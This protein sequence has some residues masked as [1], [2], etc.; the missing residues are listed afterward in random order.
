VV[1]GVNLLG[2]ARH[3][4][5]ALPAQ[6]LDGGEGQHDQGSVRHRAIHHDTPTDLVARES[7]LALGTTG[8]A[9]L[10]ELEIDLRSNFLVGHLRNDIPPERGQGLDVTD[11]HTRSR[12]S[13]QGVCHPR[14][15]RKSVMPRRRRAGFMT[16]SLTSSPEGA[17]S[18]GGWRVS[19]QSVQGASRSESSAKTAHLPPPDPSDFLT[20]CIWSLPWRPRRFH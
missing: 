18:A 3:L 13:R 1:G 8:A 12:P 10:V 11:F 14:F 6:A 20:A 19:R 16:L 9:A 7:G 2:T 17:A 15:S 5:L 4:A